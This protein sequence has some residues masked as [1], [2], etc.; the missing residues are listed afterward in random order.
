MTAATRVRSLLVLLGIGVA[1][2]ATHAQ[3][4]SQV[5]SVQPPPKRTESAAGVAAPPLSEEERKLAGE[6]RAHVSWLAGEV[7]ERHLERELDL[8]DATD[9]LVSEIESYGYAVNRMGVVAGDAVAQNIEVVIPG[10]TR[11]TEQVVV[12]AHY[13]THP[14]SPGADDNASGVAA[15]LALARHMAGQAFSRTLR[16]VLFCNEEQPHFMSPSMGSLAYAKT[17]KKNR[18][19]VVGMLSIE[20]IGYYTDEPGSQRY[21]AAVADRYPSVGNFLAV[22]AN[23]ESNDLMRRVRDAMKGG[24]LPIV[25]DALPEDVPGVAWSDHWAFWRVDYPAVMV[26]ATAP[27]RNPN[28]HRPSDLPATLDYDRMARAV[29][30]IERAVIALVGVRDEA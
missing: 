1:G 26:T 15:V 9:G 4:T 13:D 7:G 11:G 27:F 16:L 21:P 3:T 6:L 29:T 2:C 20:A 8:A 19:E 24:V 10:D 14:G 18:V 28:Y 12:G 25:A 23:E 22:V 5:V 30:A 17:L